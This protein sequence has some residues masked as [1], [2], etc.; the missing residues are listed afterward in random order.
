MSTALNFQAQPI[1]VTA[2][3]AEATITPKLGVDM[4]PGGKLS[5]PTTSPYSGG[6]RVQVVNNAPTNLKSAAPLSSRAAA[7]SRL[8]ANIGSKVAPIASAVASAGPLLA[9]TAGF[10]GL[11]GIFARPAGLGS[12][13]VGGKPIQPYSEP[14]KP[15]NSAPQAKPQVKTQPEVRSPT[16]FGREDPFAPIFDFEEPYSPKPTPAP[17][18]AP[19]PAP[20]P[21]KPKPIPNPQPRS[22]IDF[23]ANPGT[24]TITLSPINNQTKTLTTPSLLDEVQTGGVNLLTPIVDFLKKLDID[25]QQIKLNLQEFQLDF[26]PL[27]EGISKMIDPIMEAI[28]AIPE[29]FPDIIKP[30]LEGMVELV[31]PLANLTATS[32]EVS[33]KTPRTTSEA[34]AEFVAPIFLLITLLGTALDG[35]GKAISGLTLKTGIQI[36]QGMAMGAQIPLSMAAS[37]QIPMGMAAAAQIPVG[38]AAS[39]QIPLGMAAAAQIPVIQTVLAELPQTLTT[40]AELTEITALQKTAEDLAKCCKDIQDKMKKKKK[41]DDDRFPEFKSEGLIECDGASIPYAYAG[42]GLK[43]LHQQQNIILGISKMVLKKVCDIDTNSVSFPDIFGSG[44]YVCDETFGT[45]NYSGVGLLGL[46]SQLDRVLDFNKKILSEVCDLDVPSFSFPDI[47]GG[48]TYVCDET[49]GTYN[50]SGVGLLGLQSQ[51]DRVLDFN[52]KILREVCDL[53]VPSFSFPDI[54]GGGTYVCDGSITNYEYSGPG[55]IGLSNQIGELTKVNTK[56]LAEVCDNE[57]IIGQL[58][59]LDCEGNTQVLLYS[60]DGSIGLSSQINALTHLTKLT[61]TKV[62][63]TPICVPVQPGD[64]FAEFDVPRQ[65]VIT[66]GENYPTQKG[67]LWHTQIPNPRE[68]L[69]WCQDFENLSYIKGN[70][71][72]RLL[73]GNSKIKSG[74]RCVGE[75]EADRILDLIALLSTSTGKKRFTKGGGVKLDPA[76]RPVRCVRAAIAQLNAEGV[77]EVVQCFVPPPGGC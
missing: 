34:V 74:M 52:K 60:G 71:Y 30:I 29:T 4:S 37:A 48:G 40:A 54:F 66:W 67:S 22:A 75:D 25:I 33:S 70:I 5:A 50:Y 13:M 32:I 19:T 44:T 56:I 55:L 18:S 42:D 65:L 23:E 20:A 10:L 28:T 3:V 6:P 14:A 69:E 36:P 61:Y 72:G 62:C 59:F 9:A 24:G 46:Q 73:W 1:T 12:D 8:G 26:T 35:I 39:A 15:V 76:V 17:T 45:Y 27:L 41:D 68:D 7:A 51:L 57:N 64:E 63:E 77:A 31:T 43:G 53:D 2:T 49:F 38:M 16:T 47:F 58:D 21:F 11:E